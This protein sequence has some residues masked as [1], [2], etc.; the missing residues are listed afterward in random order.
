M[1][2]TTVHTIKSFLSV[3]ACMHII[4]F[5]PIQ[6]AIYIYIY[7]HNNIMYNIYII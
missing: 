5:N 2:Y 6:Y 3:H 4:C 1:T 7:A